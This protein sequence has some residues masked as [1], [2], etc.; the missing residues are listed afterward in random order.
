MIHTRNN[1]ILKYYVFYWQINHVF[2]RFYIIL[3]ITEKRHFDTL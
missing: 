2:I 1:S 3:T